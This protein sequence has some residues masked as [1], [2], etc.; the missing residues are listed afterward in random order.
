MCAVWYMSAFCL[1]FEATWDTKRRQTK[2]NCKEYVRQIMQTTI[3]G[4]NHD[5][6]WRAACVRLLVHGRG[7]LHHVLE[8]TDFFTFYFNFFQQRFTPPLEN[9]YFQSRCSFLWRSHEI[10]AI[11]FAF[12]LVVHLPICANFCDFRSKKKKKNS[13]KSLWLQIIYSIVGS[14]SGF[15]STSSV[16]FKLK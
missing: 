10:I 2:S 11:L 4:V 3:A 15:Q 9:N 12:S 1:R 7:E 16:F 13:S 5:S 6:T 14:K 8:T